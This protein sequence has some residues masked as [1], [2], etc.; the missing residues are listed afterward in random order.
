MSIPWQGRL[1][2][3]IDHFQFTC[4]LRNVIGSIDETHIPFTK[5][6]STHDTI[7]PTNF[8]CARKGFNLLYTNL[9]VT[10]I[11]YFGMY[12]AICPRVQLARGPFQSSSIYDQLQVREI[13][14]EH[15]VR[16]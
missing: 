11:V 1:Q 6:P 3:M 8:Y 16:V 5:K 7:V 9:C 2:E 4:T 14:K 15:V 12:V 13:L 10:H